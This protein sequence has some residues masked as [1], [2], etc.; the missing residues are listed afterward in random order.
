MIYR[1]IYPFLY[2]PNVAC[3]LFKKKHDKY[4]I[5]LVERTDSP[6]HWQLPQGGRD[7]LS[8]ENAGLKELSEEINCY[9]YKLIAVFA[10]L[11]K[12]NFD[13]E[14]GLEKIK[15]ARRHYGYKGQKQSLLIVQFTGKDE[16]IRVNY[17]DHS[18]WKWI[19]A[20]RLVDEVAD[21]RKPGAAIF[22][23]KFKETVRY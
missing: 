6:G 18:A 4:H 3:L 7:G 15:P 17:W 16:D 22:L 13:K 20:D 19:E 21:K 1:F 5:L 14:L 2:R 11:W 9:H 8:I 12:Y 10:D 23:K